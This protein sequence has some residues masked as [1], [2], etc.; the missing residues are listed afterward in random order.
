VWVLRNEKEKHPSIFPLTPLL[1]IYYSTLLIAKRQNWPMDKGMK[2]L[3][4]SF[5][6]YNW[7]PAVKR[8]LEEA[9]SGIMRGG[10]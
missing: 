5:I 7:V 9:E 8:K 6:A 3:I 1:I 4:F 2:H 10:R